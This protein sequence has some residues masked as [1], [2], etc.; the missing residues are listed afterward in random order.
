MSY[1]FF[2]EIFQMLNHIIITLFSYL[3]NI[4]TQIMFTNAN[5]M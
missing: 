2:L 4:E 1:S 5:N 3:Y